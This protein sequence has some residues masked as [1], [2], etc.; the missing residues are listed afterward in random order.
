MAVLGTLFVPPNV[1][2]DA[3][4][5]LRGCVQVLMGEAS[6]Y[7]RRGG[8]VV[9][10]HLVHLR[11]GWECND[12]SVKT[13]LSWATG[14]KQLHQQGKDGRTWLLLAFTVYGIRCAFLKAEAGELKSTEFKS[15]FVFSLFIDSPG[16]D[17]RDT[18]R[19]LPPFSFRRLNECVCVHLGFFSHAVTC[20]LQSSHLQSCCGSSAQTLARLSLWDQHKNGY[21][22][23]TSEQCGEGFNLFFKSRKAEYGTHISLHSWKLGREIFPSRKDFG[24]T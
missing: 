1:R 10:A 14:N 15:R 24:R 23:V 19:W 11:F 12:G 22:M 7:L 16:E 8:E 3:I 6:C 17:V 9:T 4:L 18:Y 20:F 13:S 21:K 5:S 2:Q